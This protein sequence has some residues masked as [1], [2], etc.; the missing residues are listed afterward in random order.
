[1]NFPIS[2][3]LS[4]EPLSSKLYLKYKLLGIAALQSTNIFGLGPLASITHKFRNINVSLYSVHLNC[5][6]MS[7]ISSISKLTKRKFLLRNVENRDHKKCFWK[8]LNSVVMEKSYLAWNCR[9]QRSLNY[10][11]VSPYL[12]LYCDW[13]AQ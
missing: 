3:S 8:V 11:L 6:A 10:F 5:P 13:S 12:H 9:Q 1:M 7:Q 4:Q 2:Q